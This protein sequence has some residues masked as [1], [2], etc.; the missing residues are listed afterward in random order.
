[1]WSLN[2]WRAGRDS[3]LGVMGG[4]GRRPEGATPRT[5]RSEVTMLERAKP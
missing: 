1:M 5:P 3:P 4:C 2:D